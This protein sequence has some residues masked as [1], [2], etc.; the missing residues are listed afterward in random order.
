MSKR[1]WKHRKTPILWEF[2][3]LLHI[4]RD[5]HVSNVKHGQLGTSP[6]REYKESHGKPGVPAQTKAQTMNR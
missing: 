3:N 4:S 1:S 6:L 5:K 2:G